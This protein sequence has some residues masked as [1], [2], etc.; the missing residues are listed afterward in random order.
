MPSRTRSFG[1][2]FI[3]S[4][5]SFVPVTAGAQSSPPPRATGFVQ[6][7]WNAPLQA[8]PQGSLPVIPDG[9]VAGHS[10]QLVQA[11]FYLQGAVDERFGYDLRANFA[12]GFSLLAAYVTWQV[13]EDMVFQ[14]GQMLKPFGRDRLRSRHRLLTFDRALSTFEIVKGRY[15]GHWDVGALL[16]FTLPQEDILQV[17]LFN[18]RG[19]GPVRD[20]DTGKNLVARYT[21]PFGPIE[22]G[23]G[24]SLLH[25]STLP[26]EARENQALGLDAVWTDGRH[27]LEVELLQADDWQGL[28]PVT[29]RTPTMQGFLLTGALALRPPAGT[30]AAELALRVERFRPDTRDSDLDRTLVVPN[31]NLWITPAARLQLG[32]V[33]ERSNGVGIDPATSAVAL[34]QA[35]FF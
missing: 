31:L 24:Y 2:L 18:G 15:Y 21:R 19:T 23:V 13:K 3:A 6:V 14:A 9:A 27:T 17:G 25:L 22:L 26:T 20:N 5:L 4:V 28:D 12:G 1:L 30:H 33:H 34:L 7:G 29:G 32:F 8:E 11:R 16:R 10:F 35:N